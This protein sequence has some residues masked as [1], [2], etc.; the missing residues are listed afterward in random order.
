MNL[1]VS[2]SSLNQDKVADDTVS[3]YLGDAT[4]SMDLF[5]IEHG[6]RLTVLDTCATPRHNWRLASW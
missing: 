5:H 6:L 1:K 2:N 4:L 3:T